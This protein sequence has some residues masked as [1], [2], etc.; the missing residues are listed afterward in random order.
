[1][2]EVFCP[3]SELRVTF[4]FDEKSVW[5]EY[6][7]TD[8]QTKGREPFAKSADDRYALYEG[9]VFGGGDYICCSILLKDLQSGHY[10][11]VGESG[12]MYGGGEESGF[13]SNGDVYLFG[14][15]EFI[16]YEKGMPTH[17]PK[18]VLGDR[19]PLGTVE[20]G[21]IR[22][23][24]LFA[25]RRDPQAFTYIVMYADCPV[26]T[27][28]AQTES[29]LWQLEANGKAVTYKIGLLN[30]NGVLQQSFDT[31]VPVTSTPFGYNTVDMYL[32]GA[33]QLYFAVKGGK[34]GD[35]YGEGVF[36]LTTFTTSFAWK[37]H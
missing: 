30:E 29:F 8:S 3:Y 23:R 4:R 10:T 35:V 36:D 33:D 24:L 5:E 19:F 9:A 26:D 32:Q 7:I 11:Y 28:S 14:R 13:F 6:S 16:I 27:F 37:E 1:M 18:F 12:G 20:E 2:A 31:G 17:T 25:V 22:T 15:T 34:Q 21:N